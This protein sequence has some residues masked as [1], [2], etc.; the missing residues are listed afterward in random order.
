MSNMNMSSKKPTLQDVAEAAGVSTATISRCLNQ[1][2]MV[3]ENVRK[4]IHDA[5][6][7]LGYVPHGAARALA[8]S[9]THTIGIIVPTIDNA[10]FAKTIQHLQHDIAK[11]NYTLLVACSTYSLDEELREVQS[12]LTRGID[13]LVLIGELHHPAVFAALEQQAVPYVNLWTYKQTSQH[14]CIGFDNVN[15][16][17]QLAKHLSDLGHSNIGI[18]SGFTENNDRALHRMNGAINYIQSQGKYVTKVIECKYSID[19]G[20]SAMKTIMQDCPETTAI[21]CGNDILAIGAI[22]GARELGLV[23]PED[24]SISGFDN[25]EIASALDKPLTTISVP[26]KAMGTEAARFLLDRIDKKEQQQQLIKL[27]A[28]LIIGETTTKPKN[29]R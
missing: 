6:N 9:K 17:A 16:G 7:I 25:I 5:I 14:N 12:L 23:V 21:F 11:H 2:D 18:I 4:K 29:T 8:S 19:K 20:K 1:P 10:I 24:I 13:G 28:D 27:D 22:A 15:S 3:K 26:A